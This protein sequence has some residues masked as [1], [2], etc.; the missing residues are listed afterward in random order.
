M[1]GDLPPAIA[2]AVPESLFLTA[3]SDVVSTKPNHREFPEF[4]AGEVDEPGVVWN[5]AHASKF[6]FLERMIK[7]DVLS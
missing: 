7:H 5:F 4:L 2:F 3:W 1:S 6:V